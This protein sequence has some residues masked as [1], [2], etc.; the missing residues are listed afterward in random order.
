MS[1]ARATGTSDES[2]PRR[3]ATG[4]QSVGACVRAGSRSAAPVSVRTGVCLA[5][6]VTAGTV[7]HAL[8]PS[9]LAALRDLGTAADAADPLAPVVVVASAGAWALV[10]W[11]AAVVAGTAAT[12]LPGAAG[13]IAGCLTALVAPVAVRRA[14]AMTLGVSV[15]TGMLAAPVSATG[16]AGHLPTT[17]PP[18]VAGAPLPQAGRVSLDWGGAPAPLVVDSSGAGP[19][20]PPG[21]PTE[22]TPAPRQAPTAAPDRPPTPAPAPAPDRPPTPAPKQAPKQ[23]PHSAPT[24]ASAPTPTSSPATAAAATPSRA[25][26]PAPSP[27][28][29][30][31][32]E[33]AAP[34]SSPTARPAAAAAGTG[35][36]V[37]VRPGDSLWSI[38]AADLARR[39][40]ARP[41]DAR[42]ATAW[43]RWW[44]ANRDTVGDDPDLL[45]P[46]ARLQPPG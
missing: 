30:P 12:G 3:P 25:R 8:A 40:G 35:A 41:P 33:A 6:L 2:A 18:P 20:R 46:G 28:S 19:A 27:P 4:A 15:A 9:P 21:A 31:A 42:V 26:L 14:V 34:P 10:G 29:A 37:V 17:G 23:A 45:L 11:L 16:R 5:A 36:P 38:A 1:R 32:P 13:R 43:P 22:A 44:S 7:L 24:P 39:T